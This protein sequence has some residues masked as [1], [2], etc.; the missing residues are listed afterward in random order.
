MGP[1]ANANHQRGSDRRYNS[2]LAQSDR[3]KQ[4][5]SDRTSAR[6]RPCIAQKFAS[7]MSEF[8]PQVWVRCRNFVG[9]GVRVLLLGCS[10]IR[11]GAWREST[12]ALLNLGEKNGAWSNSLLC[13]HQFGCEWRARELV[14]PRKSRMSPALCVAKLRAST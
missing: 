1:A 7:C 6:L 5:S 4:S 3:E 2:L 14:W 10:T 13:V 9:S 11:R 12:I 8:E